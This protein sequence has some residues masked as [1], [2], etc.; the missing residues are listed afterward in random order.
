[1]TWNPHLLALAVRIEAAYENSRRRRMPEAV[2]S[3]AGKT[4]PTPCGGATKRNAAARQRARRIEQERLTRD[5]EHLLSELRYAPRG[6]A[7]ATAQRYLP[8][9]KSTQS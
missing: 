1:M 5:L 4:F 2:P 8:P 9:E 7:N 6:A 3:C